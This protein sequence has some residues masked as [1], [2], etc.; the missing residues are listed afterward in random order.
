MPTQSLLAVLRSRWTIAGTIFAL[1]LGAA[2][3]LTLLLPPRYTASADVLVNLSGRDG[4]NGPAMPAAAVPAYMATQVDIATS[5][6]AA[7]KVVD[8]LKLTEDAAVLRAWRQATGGAGSIRHHLSDR[9]L[10]SLRVRQV[11]T[12]SVLS[13]AYVAP[14]P[15]EAA[16]IANAFADAYAELT[17]ELGG[18]APA[19]PPFEAA[20]R[21]GG[22]MDPLAARRSRASADEVDPSSAQD[23]PTGV[24]P[25][26]AVGPRAAPPRRSM[27]ADVAV[28]A[29][30]VPSVRPSS[31]RPG[32]LVGI[33][34]LLGAV[35]ALAGAL[36]A[37]RNDRRVRGARDLQRASGV[38]PMCTLR[39][40]FAGASGSGPAGRTRGGLG[41]AGTDAHGLETRPFAP[42]AAGS[43]SDRAGE[44]GV[45]A[46]PRDGARGH[47]PLG[48]IMVSAGLIH[49]PEVQRILEWARTDGVRFGEAAVAH[50][51]VTEAQVER[52]LAR[53]FD[54][55]MLEAGST[56]VSAEVVAA[57]DA[58]NPLVAD[59]RRLRARIRSA[60]LAAPADAPLKT[61]AVI[62]SGTGDGKTFV[63][64]NLAVAF[65]QAGQRTLLV[66]ADLRRG[67]LH[68]VFGLDNRLGLSS[69]LNRR[70]EPGSLQR[71]PGL[72]D[73]GVVTC[74][75]SA[76]NPSELLSRDVFV[77]LLASFSRAYDVVILDTPG[78]SEEPDATL[79]AQR[80]GAALVIARKDLSAFDAV[81]ELVRSGG[82][83]AVPVLGSVLNAV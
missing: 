25:R 5:Q 17:A 57:F 21:D 62:S 32:R 4:G 69:M 24:R 77:H 22:D 31:P 46:A 34:V 30:A 45:S 81:V 56:R 23:G 82:T 42:E 53:Q 72:P 7:L 6:R 73:L 20:S 33:G 13:I 55:P 1:T 49:P 74:G 29:R 70:I 58:R 12:S 41:R 68:T 64:A 65:S 14:D 51:L 47:V 18:D 40:A 8:A 3:A 36:V 28:L 11:G 71:V 67:R 80:A 78:A 48:Q 79:I 60:Q 10:A 37:E 61:F 83:P 15:L 44:P 35:L 39:D 63:S 26:T 19:E 2:I 54:F 75:P 27:R 43:R 66:D 9:L 76:P 52:A 50:R 16:S 38:T 59:L